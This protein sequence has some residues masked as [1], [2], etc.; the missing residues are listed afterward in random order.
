MQQGLFAPAATHTSLVRNMHGRYFV[1]ARFA[2]TIICFAGTIIYYNMFCR[3]GTMI[4]YYNMFCRDDNLLQ[5]VL[6]ARD[7]Y[8]LY[9]PVIC[10]AGSVVDCGGSHLDP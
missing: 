4:I 2:G 6:R 10:F 3:D 7:G 8:L 1:I 9:D 5:H